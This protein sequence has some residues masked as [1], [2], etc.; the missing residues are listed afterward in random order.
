MRG[1]GTVSLMAL[2]C[3]SGIFAQKKRAAVMDFDFAS[4]Q[5]W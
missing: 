2:L 5:R 4:V 3:S 1:S